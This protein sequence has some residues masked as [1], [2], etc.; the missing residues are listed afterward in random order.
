MI[1]SDK[2]AALAN[3]EEKIKNIKNREE[4]TKTAKKKLKYLERL[5]KIT[6]S[7]SQEKN[8]Q[9]KPSKIESKVNVKQNKVAKTEV[10][11][12]NAKK[13]VKREINSTNKNTKIGKQQKQVKQ[14]IEA[15]GSSDE[16]ESEEEEDSGDEEEVGEEDD[17]S[18]VEAEQ[19]DGSDVEEEQ[20]DVDEE[21]SDDD[22]EE[23]DEEDIPPQ[24]KK[25]LKDLRKTPRKKSDN[26][27]E[28]DDLKKTNLVMKNQKRFVLFVGNIPYDTNKQDLIEHFKKCGEIKHIRIPTEKKSNK[29][30]GFAYVEV[31]NEETYQRC[32]SMHHTSLKER[33]INV[34]YTQGGKKKGEDKKKEIKAK[35]FK[36]HAMRKEGKLAGSKK[37]NQK[38]SFRRAKQKAIKEQSE[39]QE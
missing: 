9:Q 32:L 15:E 39:N 19:D 12:L 10:A 7:G 38:R 18:D 17:G 22:E 1:D 8:Q 26:H 2:D 5:K 4:L 6:V 24:V 20:D 28:L 14:A 33:R 27:V 16:E 11:K 34:L 30:R 31:G 21:E 3:I 25:T 37:E 29:A 36:L 13:N 35:N 23:S